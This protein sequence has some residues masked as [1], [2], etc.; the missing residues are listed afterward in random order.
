MVLQNKYHAA[1][2][3]TGWLTPVQNI[4]T[5]HLWQCKE[6]KPQW[7]ANPKDNLLPPTQGTDRQTLGVMQDNDHVGSLSWIPQPV[8]S[9]GSFGKFC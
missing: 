3:D 2:E 9:K 6:S 4:Q 5:R 1:P 8:D 7:P